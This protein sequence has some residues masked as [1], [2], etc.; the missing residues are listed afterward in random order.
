MTIG[1]KI[2][3]LDCDQ[4]LNKQTKKTRRPE[5]VHILS[6]ELFEL[7][8]WLGSNVKCF[9]YKIWQNNIWKLFV[10]S[11]DTLAASAK[12]SVSNKLNKINYLHSKKSKSKR[13][14]S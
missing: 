6:Y 9:H 8:T 3:E 2:N 7:S 11:G 10:L 4:Q 14:A 12:I 13:R 5:C 1:H